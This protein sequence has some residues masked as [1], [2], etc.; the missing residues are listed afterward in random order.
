VVTPADYEEAARSFLRDVVLPQ[1]LG[2][3]P[4]AGALLARA[5]GNVHVEGYADVQWD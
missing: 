2:L 5:A 4:L 3:V 1:W